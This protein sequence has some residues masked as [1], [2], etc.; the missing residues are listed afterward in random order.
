MLIKLEIF[1]L[2]RFQL[3]QVYKKK[4]NTLHSTNMLVDVFFCD[5]YESVIRIL[6]YPVGFQK[7]EEFEIDVSVQ[8][9]YGFQCISFC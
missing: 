8:V 9:A 7:T 3:S 6:P 5:E 2:S 1:Q 4:Q